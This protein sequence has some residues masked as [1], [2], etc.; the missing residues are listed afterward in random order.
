SDRAAGGRV[1]FAFSGNGS[2]WHGMGVDLMA[3]V[4]AF[5]AAVTEADAVL[6]P[7][8]GW[9]VARELAAPGRESRMGRTE[10]A[11][12]ALFALQLGLVAALAE[13]GVRPDAV[14][15]HSV[16]EIAAACVAGALDLPAAARVVAERSQ[17][18]GTTAGSGRMA[19]LGVP[20]REARALL[21]PY[22]GKLEIAAVNSVRDVTVSGDETALKE[23]GHHL[24]DRDVFFRP[25]DLDYAFHSRH[26]DPLAEPMK[27]ALADLRPGALR[28]PFASTVTGRLRHAQEGT[29]LDA[30][31]WWRNLR[32]PVL[33]ADAVAAVL[34]EG[35]GALVEIGPH[36]VLTAYVRRA[37]ET[38]RVTAA[39]L[40]TLRRHGPGREALE[41][42]VGCVLA[43]G[44][45]DWSAFF[46]VPGRVT[47]LPPYAWQREPHPLPPAASWNR[48]CGSGVL[49]H[50]LLGERAA[51]LDPGWHQR[52]DPVR[53]P[54]LADHKVSGAVLMPA[55]GYVEAVLAAGSR[56]LDGPLEVTALTFQPLTLPWDEP[57]MNVWLHTS[58]SDED[59]VVRV[60]SRTGGPGQ[61]WRAHAR[62][63]VRRL[64]GRA[65]EGLGGGPRRDFPRG[66]TA[67]EMY[68]RARRGGLDYGPCFRVL[69]YV[70]TDG[71]EA[72][73]HY[74][75]DHLDTAG[76]LAHPAILDGAL[77][78][79]AVLLDGADETAFLPAAVDTVRLWRPPTATGHIRVLA[80]SAT[81]AEAVWDVTVADE[82][83]AVRV[84]LLGCRLR[85]FD[86]GAGP[87]IS[88][89]V[90]ELRAAPRSGHV[91]AAVPLPRPRA[92]R[93][94]TAAPV[95][96]VLSASET[97]RALELTG[98]LK[99][100]TAHFAVRAVEEILPGRARF[101]WAELSGAGVLP[102]YEPLLG[103]LLEVAE[104]Y[105]LV[106]GA[107]AFRAQGA[108]QVLS[109][110]RPEETVRELVAGPL[111]RGPELTAYGM[112]GRRLPDVLTGRCD[113]L[114]LLFSESGRYLTEELYTSSL[115]SEAA[116]RAMRSGVRALV[117]AWPA[118]RPLR[119]LEVGAGTG[120]TTRTV[121]PHLPRERT[122]YVFTD[123]SESFF[124]RARARLAAHD[125]IEYQTLD[126]NR[127][128]REQGCAE[129][130]FD[131]VIA[132]NVLHA[133]ED[134]RGT[135][136]RLSFLLADDGH[137]LVQEMHDT[138]AC[139]LVFGILKSFWARTDLAERPR[140][141]LLPRERWREL[142]KE[143]G[144]GDVAHAD[145][146]GGLE[147]VASVLSARRAPRSGAVAAPPLPR[148]LEESAWIVVGEPDCDVSAGLAAFLEAAGGTVRRTGPDAGAVGWAG[149]LP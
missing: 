32:R 9:S 53:L 126:L 93:S 6:T 4:P 125:F 145:V 85:R 60:A 99:R 84:E 25:L 66:A 114:E 26:M 52:L 39:V 58:V 61:P 88:E 23:L 118:D 38:A 3:S 18:Q 7:L 115:Q 45:G 119:V 10:I 21:L 73:A 17:L 28:L 83:G 92:G 33:F 100:V 71:R 121:V 102:E 112:C 133:T 74:R 134:V 41:E 55:A 141:P 91:A 57:D 143:S 72:V 144:F 51:A 48:T 124:P 37:A 29:G 146:D 76:Y 68:H 107:D 104:E 108:C 149:L 49:D 35:C 139:A 103:V 81:A 94:A 79:D 127:D 67:D 138:A 117:G 131:V 147:Q 70:R 132:S 64:L 120:A 42:T 116:H 8:L 128:P 40:P 34:E 36:P 106:A 136:G 97:G 16:G 101:T 137:L 113:P 80:R 123:V 50:P 46:P 20:E 86:T 78:T 98:A 129:A 96:V 140:T 90:T 56:V 47:G 105:G 130:S 95:E 87:A 148:V 15:G 69:E 13:Q 11:Q 30:G 43:T 142:L 59:G 62:G 82:D 31:Y 5:R 44:A 135:L 27:A 63:R 24:A 122:R 77:Q 22:G 54:W 14:L 65:P 110:G 1:V 109:P 2:Q 111:L 19:A 75:A 89:C 12:P